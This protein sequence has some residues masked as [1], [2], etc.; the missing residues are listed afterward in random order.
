MLDAFGKK[1]EMIKGGEM[2]LQINNLLTIAIAILVL[3]VGIFIQKR[4][5]ILSRFFI[6]APVVGGLLFSIL[7]A[8]LSYFDYMHIN[9][10]ASAQ[11]YFMLIFFAT[12]G[13]AASLRFLFIGGKAVLILFACMCLL[14]IL[15]NS[16]GVSLAMLLD[17]P[18]AF[19]LVNS[20]ITMIGGHGTGLAFA[21]TLQ[22]DF[23]LQNA[24]TIT[25][26]A[27][28][29]GLIAGSLSGGPVAKFLMRKYKP[30]VTGAKMDAES[31]KKLQLH[32]PS[33]ISQE[34]I[35]NAVIMIALAIGFGSIFSAWFK[36]LNIIL[37]DYIGAMLAAAILRNCSDMTDWY[38]I[39]H[40]ELQV[41]GAISL[42][43]F[44]S[45][46]L[47]QMKLLALVNLAIPMLVILLAQVV[48]MVLFAIFVI[49][50]LLGKSY[51]A[52]VMTCGTVGLGM[53]ATPNAIA[54]MDAF[55]A[56]NRPAPQAFF[57]VP[58]VGSV[59]I[60]FF[61]AGMITAF[62]NIF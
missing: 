60:D 40:T 18:T 57:V 59:L 19:G 32:K 28:T 61:N 49:Y 24:A 48:L 22:N 42:S 25:A 51:D 6:P 44:L 50:K 35:F 10:D 12:I 9:F 1:R 29:V 3:L 56:K 13:F 52:V 27:A 14:V 2:L 58:I 8:V 54:N 7:V 34:G 37:P 20:S 4:V 39:S 41:L 21:G 31:L 47:M 45:M 16:L 55:V 23:G 36:S 26:A 53:G 5:N 17:M 62:L 30:E 43:I 33:K 11:Q 38:E 15:Q 46:A